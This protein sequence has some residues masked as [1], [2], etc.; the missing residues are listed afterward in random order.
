MTVLT[1]PPTDGPSLG[2]TAIT[3]GARTTTNT[4]DPSYRRSSSSERVSC[5]RPATIAGS[6]QRTRLDVPPPVAATLIDPSVQCTDRVP[7]AVPKTLTVEAPLAPLRDGSMRCTCASATN[8]KRPPIPSSTASPL[9]SCTANTTTPALSIAGDT[10][11]KLEAA[12]TAASAGT[13]RTSREPSLPPNSHSISEWNASP[14]T[15]TLV[16]PETGPRLGPMRLTSGWRSTTY[17]SSREAAPIVPARL[18]TSTVVL[19]IRR[20]GIT[21]STALVDRHAPRTIAVPPTRHLSA[22]VFAK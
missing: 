14:P 18:W 1:V 17:F 12:P 6:K 21:H 5:T 13:S 11:V 3:T 7:K 2:S 8:S 20:A 19:P 9:L 10:H 15:V 4:T 22:S 16:P